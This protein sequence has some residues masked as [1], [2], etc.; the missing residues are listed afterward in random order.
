MQAWPRLPSF[1]TNRTYKYV[2]PLKGLLKQD[3]RI[4]SGREKGLN[5]E[6]RKSC[7]THAA[8]RS[9]TRG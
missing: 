5:L 8:T 7:K 6:L 3:L 9:R 2:V 4:Y 1:V